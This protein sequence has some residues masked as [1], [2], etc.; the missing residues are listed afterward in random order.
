MMMMTIVKQ[1]PEQ[2]TFPREY[3]DL[4]K[5]CWSKDPT[6]RPSFLVL[7]IRFFFLTKINKYLF[8]QFF[9][10]SGNYDNFK[11]VDYG[12]LTLVQSVKCFVSKTAS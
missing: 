3:T 6:V 8:V 4:M 10:S 1:V 12:Q 9:F 2:T 5:I 7:I 11:F